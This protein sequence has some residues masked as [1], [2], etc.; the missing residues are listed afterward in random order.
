MRNRH[1]NGH[2]LAAI[3]EEFSDSANPA[4]FRRY[5]LTADSVWFLS[6]ICWQILS[7]F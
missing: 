6:P 7:D 3:L 1:K 4:R 5:I 2:Y